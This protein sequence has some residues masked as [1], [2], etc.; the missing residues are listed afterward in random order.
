MSQTTETRK[1]RISELVDCNGTMPPQKKRRLEANNT[2]KD[3]QTHKSLECFKCG[4]VTN[5]AEKEETKDFHVDCDECGERAGCSE[6]WP[7][8]GSYCSQCEEFWCYDCGGVK[9]CDDCSEMYCDECTDFK[10]GKGGGI[11]CSHCQPWWKKN[12]PASAF[13]SE[14]GS[15]RS[16]AHFCIRCN[17]RFCNECP[18]FTCEECG[19]FECENCNEMKFCEECGSTY[20]SDCGPTCGCYSEKSS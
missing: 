18:G 16:N 10:P 8:Y 15:Q 20:C 9:I 5:E 7:D 13:C 2:N 17:K 12:K 19:D 11:Q 1:R 3:E 4:N 14:C 6:C